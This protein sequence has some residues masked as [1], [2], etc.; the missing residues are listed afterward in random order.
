MER[1]H[2]PQWNH[3]PYLGWFHY[4]NNITI[5]VLDLPPRTPT[6]PRINPYLGFINHALPIVPLQQKKDVAVQTDIDPAME[7]GDQIIKKSGL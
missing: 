6:L 5:R 1:V 4:K 7:L 3:T 2:I